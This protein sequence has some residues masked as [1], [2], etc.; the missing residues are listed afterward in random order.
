MIH[1]TCELYI[2]LFIRLAFVVLFMV[3]TFESS[4]TT[5]VPGYEV[6]FGGIVRR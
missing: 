3:V 1:S 2:S 6:V 5:R 4:L